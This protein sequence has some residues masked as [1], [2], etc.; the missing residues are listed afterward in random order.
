[1]AD[2]LPHPR[3]ARGPRP[4][5]VDMTP[6]VDLAFLLLSFFI[7]TTALRRQQG[8]ELATG[9]GSGPAS[10]RT[11]TF[12]WAG[13]DSLFAYTGTFHP[14]ATR[15]KRLGLDQAAA[16][17]TAVTDTTGLSIGVKT[18][19]GVRYAEVVALVDLLA[20]RHLTRFAVNEGLDPAERDALAMAPVP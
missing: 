18:A 8:L 1:M 14:P 4:I 20:Q 19:G 13:H 3:H 5:R 2:M 7:L 10:D 16:F 6:L 12:L 15:P 17:L 11:I 9:L